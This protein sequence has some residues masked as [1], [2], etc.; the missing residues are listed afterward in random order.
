MLAADDEAI[1]EGEDVVG[2]AVGVMECVA[3]VEVT[4]FEDDGDIDEGNKEDDDLRTRHLDVI[5]R[6]S[7]DPAE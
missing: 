5:T 6:F 1:F 4:A 7:K 2:E 3:I